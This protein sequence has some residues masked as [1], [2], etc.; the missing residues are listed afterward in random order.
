MSTAVM[1]S[2]TSPDLPTYLMVVMHLSAQLLQKTGVKIN[3]VNEFIPTGDGV[4]SDSMQAGWGQVPPRSRYV[5]R[6]G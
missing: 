2:C 1:L 6:K 5:Y 4:S 3:L